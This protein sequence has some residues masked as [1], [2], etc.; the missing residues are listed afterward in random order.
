VPILLAEAGGLD[1]GCLIS[2]FACC[3]LSAVMLYCYGLMPEGV[4]S[5]IALSC[6]PSITSK[7]LVVL[8]VFADPC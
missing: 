4:W 6:H 5:E 1:P 8:V 2:S 3:Y 7:V